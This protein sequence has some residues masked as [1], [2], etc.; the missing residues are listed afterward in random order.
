[1]L[2]SKLLVA[3]ATEKGQTTKKVF[4]PKGKWKS[5]EGKMYKGGQVITIDV[6]LK[7]LPYFELVK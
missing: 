2:G 1:M 4:L 5:D 7:R 6:P 3:P